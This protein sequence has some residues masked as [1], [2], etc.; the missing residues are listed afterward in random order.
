MQHLGRFGI[1]LLLLFLAALEMHAEGPALPLVMANLN[2]T[3][4]G[5]LENGV[6]ELRLEL[7]QGRWYP[8]DENGDHRYIYAFAEEGHLPQS[9]G[10]LIRVLQGTQIHATIH[11]ALVLAARIY[12]LHRHPGDSKDALLLAPGQTRE[13]HFLAGEPGT[14]LYWATTSDKPQ[15]LR[16]QAETL[17]SGAFIVD[18]P[19]ART[20]DRVFMIG[21]WNKGI[22]GTPGSDEILS[23]NGKSWPYTERLSY[24]IGEAIHWRVLN[25]TW[26]DHAM[27][28]HGFYFKV[29]GV[30]DG[31][32]YDR[33][34]EEQRRLAVTEHIDVGHV[35]EMTWTPERGGNWL[36]HCHMLLHMSSTAVL[37]TALAPKEGQSANYS[38]AH[39][40][41]MGMG[42]LVIGITV[43]PGAMP[44]PSPVA[45]TVTR[46]LQLVISDNP[47]K[48]P[49][50]NLEVNDSLKPIA[51]DKNTPPSLVGPPIFLTRG[52]A[53]EIEV[54]NQ[55]S[56]PTVIHWHG[57]ELE[58]YYDGV[59]GWT[60]SGQ[61]TTPPVAPGT[62]FIAR[63]T[64]PRAGTFIYH[65]HWHDDVQLRNGL[66][67]PLIV[68]EQG[69][70]YNAEH[71]RTF[72]FSMGK[73]DP[74]GFML[75]VNGYPQ[76]DPVELHTA[77]RYRLRLINI[78]DGAADL[79][80][81][82]TNKGVPV[83]WKVIAKD[84]AN[85]PPAQ[86]RLATADMGI[87]VG[88]TYD[89]EYQA[90]SPGIADLEIRQPSFPTPVTLPL[91][92]VVAK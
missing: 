3:A 38:S 29:D 79:R 70:K 58:S 78:T 61:Q 64:P 71:D 67:G 83:Q 4:A 17:L 86:L 91:Q 68:L 20:D 8:E 12:G 81:R 49:L 60:G 88:S 24:K 55:S 19:G 65:T 14:Y 9:S 15:A 80:V 5:Q 56:N 34:S 57:I 48:I 90:D 1:M 45:A 46:K 42:G 59:A 23:I 2:R 53:T 89:V 51:T 77:T 72:V 21:I 28:L 44:P 33:Y 22:P 13:L 16:D 7:R 69:Q 47:G 27:H 37:A 87:T 84:G 26:S 31:E 11:N 36:F 41:N 40:H 75:L 43:L 62:S 10:P 63:M 25:P 52:E 74:F 39:E 18:A 85:L 73:Y 92:F 76:P 30:G 32:H 66:Y 6:L 82:L 54:K 35:F 50:Y